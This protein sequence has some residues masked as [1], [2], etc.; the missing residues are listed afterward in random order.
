MLDL[1]LYEK[2]LGA[3]TLAEGHEVS[4]IAHINDFIDSSPNRVDITLEGAVSDCILSNTNKSSIKEILLRP[5][6]VVNKGM[7]IEYETNKYL[8]L[9][10][11]PNKI[12]PKA[13][14]ELCNNTLRWR[15]SLSNLIELPCIIKGNVFEEVT[16]KVERQIITSDSELILLVQLNSQSKTIN[17]N[18]RF[19]FDGYAFDVKSI[20]SL[21]HSHNGVGLMKLSLNATSIT[22]TDD[23]TGG[24][25]D[26]SGSSG[27]GSW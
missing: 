14:I 19:V 16:G 9:D 21:S 1:T 3:T 7:L 10:Y 26:D 27:W 5:N 18:Q 2:T 20:D 6:T 22:S 13:E 24:V 17:P 11:R 8:V 12:Y 4:T 15:D 25:A 23:T